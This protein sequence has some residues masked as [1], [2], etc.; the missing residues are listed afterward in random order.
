MALYE[1]TGIQVKKL[2]IIM[3]CEDGE[4]AVY[5]ERDLDKYMKLVVKYIRKFVAD[6]LLTT[7]S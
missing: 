4:C 1:M 2:V 5:K 7:G 6:K 3:A